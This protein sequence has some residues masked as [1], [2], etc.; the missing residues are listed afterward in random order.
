MIMSENISAL[1]KDSQEGY[2]ESVYSKMIKAGHRTYFLDVRKTRTNDKFIS[3]TEV[4]KK[5]TEAGVVNDR[6]K[7]FVYQED[8][9]KF[10]EGLKDVLNFYEQM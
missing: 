4:R 9:D 7:V 6:N 2:G 8:L 10:M 5:I 3:I 1:R